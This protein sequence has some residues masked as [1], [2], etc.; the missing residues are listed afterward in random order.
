MVGHRTE[1]NLH[2]QLP[3][4]NIRTIAISA[5]IPNI[6]DIAQWLNAPP[7]AVMEFGDELRPVKLNTIVRGYAPTKTDFLF[8]RR[9]SDHILNVIHEHS[10]EK[11]SL[12]FCR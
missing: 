11:P 12:V 2:V 6:Q 8:E 4:A 10:Q 9:L 5:S 7:A 3:I 1:L